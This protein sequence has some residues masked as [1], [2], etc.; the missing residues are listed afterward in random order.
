MYDPKRQTCTVREHVATHV[1]ALPVFSA[2]LHMVDALNY[3][4]EGAWQQPSAQRQAL[5]ARLIPQALRV[6]QATRI[7]RSSQRLLD[8]TLSF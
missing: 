2:D 3:L 8:W 7:W 1:H 4:R 6:L 5:Q